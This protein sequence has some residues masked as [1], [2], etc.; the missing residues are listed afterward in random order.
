M[1]RDCVLD[2]EEMLKKLEQYDPK[3]D[4]ETCGIN[5]EGV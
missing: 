5:K 2:D 3:N 1:D 4:F